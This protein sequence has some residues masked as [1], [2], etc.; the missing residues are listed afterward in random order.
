LWRQKPGLKVIFMS[1]YSGEVVGKNTE[2]LRR[3]KSRF[4]MKP[5]SSR[6]LLETGRQSLDGKE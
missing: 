2:F 3:T 6:I 5:C 1:G 4:L